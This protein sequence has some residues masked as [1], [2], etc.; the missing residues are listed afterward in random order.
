ME[1]AILGI[2]VAKRKFDVALFLEHK[3]TV[4]KFNN[5]LAG[6]AMLDH[7]LLQHGAERVHACL[8]ATGT[9]GDA[10]AAHLYHAGHIV[11]LV[12]PARIKGFGQ[13]ELS[14]TKTDKADAQLIARFCSAM[15]PAPWQPPS[16][17]VKELQALVRRLEAL[18]DMLD[19][20]RN[21]LDTADGSVRNSIMRVIA[22]LEQES[23][24]TRTL[25]HD[26][27]DHHPHLRGKRDLLES[28]PGI[29]PGTSAMILAEFGDVSRFHDA[30]QMASFCGL[31]PRH[32]QSGS[33]VRGRSM[34]SKTGSS[35]IRKALFM[36]ALTAMRYN[37]VIAAFRAR[38]L[39]NGKHPMVIICAIMRKL[40][41]LAF[42]VLK[43]GRPFD[44]S[45]A[46]AA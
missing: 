9:Y 35:R 37:P 3:M 7:W 15:Q 27:I 19:Q 46:A 36:P 39:T 29:G 12:N 14:R 18:N 32:R 23:K 21:R 38:L 10:L 28:I 34:I 17:E 11:S 30:G 41:H 43:S 24:A 13:S 44:P 45:L 6:F 16:P 22:H 31:T 4:G 40:I 25:I 42:G 2:D 33:S 5:T 1:P 20:E 8:E 26:H